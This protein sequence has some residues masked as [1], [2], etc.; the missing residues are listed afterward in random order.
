MKLRP[1]HLLCT[2]KFKG[3]GYSA[4]FTAHMAALVRSLRT[5]PQQPVQ[6]ICGTDDLCTACPHNRNGTCE[7]AEKTAA[8]DR[9]LLH[10]MPTDH[11]AWSVFADAV[12]PLLEPEAFAEICSQCEWYETCARIQKSEAYYEKPDKNP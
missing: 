6:L 5:D 3:L 8:L 12:T 9:A 1:H 7:S 11:A 4:A 10:K 2:R